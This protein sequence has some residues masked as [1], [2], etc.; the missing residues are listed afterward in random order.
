MAP[1]PEQAD[2]PGALRYVSE[3]LSALVYFEVLYLHV[4]PH[5]GAP[6]G[7][8]ASGVEHPLGR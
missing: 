1:L 5:V 3:G 7:E 6:F 4:R 2:D 8:I